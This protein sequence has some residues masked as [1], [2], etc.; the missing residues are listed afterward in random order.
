MFQL[1]KKRG[2]SEYLND[3]FAFLKENWKHFL[4]NYAIICGGF[5]LILTILGYILGKAYMSFI[6]GSIGGNFSIDN[7]FGGNIAL[8]IGVVVLFFVVIVILS[9]LSYLYPLVYL[10]LY[11]EL[12]HTNFTTTEISNKLRAEIGRTIKFSI[13]SFLFTITVGILLMA[14]IILLCIT[15]IGIPIAMIGIFAL[16]AMYNLAFYLY[17]NDRRLR[18][19]E[20][21]KLA[22]DHVKNNLWPIVGSNFAMLMLIQV[23]SSVFTFIPMM[24]AFASLATSIESSSGAPESSGF[25]IAMG[26][27][28][29]LSFL[30][31]YILQNLIILNNGIIYY[32]M[33]EMNHSHHTKSEI[34][35]IGTDS[36]F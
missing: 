34:D 24:F 2:F 9:F 32:T 26:I 23:I 4:K 21:F 11:E 35:L 7:L 5:L 20:S 33:Q 31:S 12:G 14:L 17:L 6:M 8:F 3:T 29:A 19:F 25:M 1:Y 30:T 36:E 10:R 27:T 28:L 16:M 15:I 22:F 18:F 13:Y